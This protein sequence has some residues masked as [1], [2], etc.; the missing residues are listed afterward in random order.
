MYDI[1]ENT[2]SERYLSLHNKMTDTFKKHNDLSYSI[3]RVVSKFSELLPSS[4]NNIVKLSDMVTDALVVSGRSSLSKSLFNL[5]VVS[6]TLNI[7]T[8]SN[9]IT[10]RYKT[11]KQYSINIKKSYI[12]TSNNYNIYNKDKSTLASLDTLI[13]GSPILIET[14]SQYFKYTFALTLD[15]KGPISCIDIGLNL[16][17]SSY[18]L[19]SEIYYINDNNK[20]VYCTILN[21]SDTQYNLDVDRQKDNIY[22]ILLPN[23]KTNR[24]YVTLE[25]KDKTSL[26]IDKIG[27][28]QLDYEAE[29]EMVLGPIVSSYPIL[30]ASIEALG[31]L[32]SA[33]FYLSPDNK[34][35]YE[36]AA[37]NELSF[38]NTV[39]KIVAFNTVNIN[40]LKSDK[41][42]KELYLKVRLKR[43]LANDSENFYRNTKQEVASSISLI[44]GEP[45]EITVYATKELLHYGESTYKDIVN[46]ADVFVDNFSYAESKG[47]YFVKGFI[48]TPYSVNSTSEKRSVNITTRPL[49]IGADDVSATDFDPL[50]SNVY[51]YSINLDTG[52]V[53]TKL[54]TNI[55]FLLSN[56]YSKDIYSIVQKDKEIKV[57]LSLGFIKAGLEAVIFV[58][59]DSPVVL[60]D[61]TAKKMKELKVQT[62]EGYS[63]I[64][65]INEGLFDTPVSSC[66]LNT[67]YPLK[68]NTDTMYALKEGRIITKEHLVDFTNIAK[69]TTETIDFETSLSK[70]NGNSI[71]LL[72]NVLK[73]KYTEYS[74]ET[75]PAYNNTT[76]IKL[77]NKHIKK[78]SL[79]LS[80]KK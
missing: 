47:E 37:P 9:S 14:D 32:D 38:T 2:K 58:E 26:T 74:E 27:V 73:E 5:K 62:F 53:N 16:S 59:A 54:S 43:K 13:K 7:N 42:F 41:D 66:E 39:N 70:E 77:R 6:N 19:V 33:N 24:L 76:V 34:A 80:V 36:V 3:F 71:V 4:L 30:K 46:I 67:L 22:T 48:E 60:F 18:P 12:Q 78:G 51:G 61:S 72:D 8:D 44:E 65:L 28:R 29:G 25:D 21:S 50:S 57:D 68:L 10:L 11:A 40:S 63:Y 52:K 45:A 49:K 20:K 31:D 64:N 35:W 23:I 55:V 17:T 56:L 1:T 69:I 79:V 15:S 75:I